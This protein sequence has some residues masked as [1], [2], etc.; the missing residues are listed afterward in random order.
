MQNPLDRQLDAGRDGITVRLVGITEGSI[1][2]A[3]NEAK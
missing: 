1:A 3:M 2:T